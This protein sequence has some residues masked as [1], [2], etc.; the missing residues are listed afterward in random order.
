MKG[1]KAF[2]FD[3]NEAIECTNEKLTLLYRR[4]LF[5][6]VE[7][8]LYSLTC[9]LVLARER[10]WGSDT[11][12]PTAALSLGAKSNQMVLENISHRLLVGTVEIDLGLG[13]G[14]GGAHT[15]VT[16]AITVSLL[17]PKLESI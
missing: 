1:F 6:E 11:Q 2:G 15:D 17:E 13:V 10:P 16:D 5:H 8:L 12:N 4:S 3:R 9:S 7:F 14:S